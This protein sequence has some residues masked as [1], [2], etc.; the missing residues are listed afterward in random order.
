MHLSKFRI[1]ALRCLGLKTLSFKFKPEFSD[2]KRVV[3]IPCQLTLEALLRSRLFGLK[4]GL[5]LSLVVKGERALL[6]KTHFSLKK[7]FYDLF[8]HN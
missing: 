7:G 5:I 3:L 8:R 1:Y 6:H 2:L 4:E